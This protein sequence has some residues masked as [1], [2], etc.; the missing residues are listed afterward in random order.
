MSLFALSQLLVG[1]ALCTDILSFQ[2]KERVYILRCLLVSCSLISLHFVC[3]EHWTAACLGLVA[4][5]RF[6]LS[7]YS[8]SR[9]WMYFFLAA[10]VISTILTYEGI[11]S[12]LGC[13]GS[14]FGTVASFS[15]DDKRLRQLMLVGTA[16][17]LIHNVLAGSPGAVVMELFFIGSNVVGYFR[18]YIRPARQALH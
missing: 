16:L 18:F 17:W 10:S 11:L 8:T 2:F 9:R 1:I 7:I 5:T 3:L 15:N 14:L 4:A 6:L 12:L 13:G